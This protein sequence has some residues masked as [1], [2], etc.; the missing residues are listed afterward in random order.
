M[1]IG[2]MCDHSTP[3]SAG[4]VFLRV[5]LSATAKAPNPPGEAPQP[6]VLQSDRSDNTDATVIRIGLPAGNLCLSQMVAIAAKAET[7]TRAK[8]SKNILVVEDEPTVLAPETLGF[9]S[10]LMN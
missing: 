1:P 9:K 6:W 10:A 2:V 4:N 8:P 3:T 7:G 5:G